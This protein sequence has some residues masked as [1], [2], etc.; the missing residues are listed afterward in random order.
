[1]SVIKC[2]Y[3]VVYY[4]KPKTGFLDKGSFVKNRGTAHECIRFI[5]EQTKPGIY[6]LQHTVYGVIMAYCMRNDFHE[7]IVSSHHGG[8]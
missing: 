3:K 5:E 2:N 1:M 6:D 4:D 7:N 8:D